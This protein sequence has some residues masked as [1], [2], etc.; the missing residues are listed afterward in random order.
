MKLLAS[1]T[2]GAQIFVFVSI[3]ASLAGLYHYD[4]SWSTLALVF[5]GY[6]VYGCL[7]IVVTFHRQLT[8]Q[9]Y[10]THPLI[11]KVFSFLGCMSNTGSSIVWV[12]IHLKHH[13]KSDRE[14]D[15][16]SP[17]ITGW[18]VFLLKYPIDEKMK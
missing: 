8:H 16:H 6:F 17:W 10:T 9:S 11:T 2:Q 14:G 18:R 1:S 4:L 15:P 7:G 5:I 13:L 3:L 12:A